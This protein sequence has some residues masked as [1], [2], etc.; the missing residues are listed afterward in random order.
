MSNDDDEVLCVKANQIMNNG[1]LSW[2]SIP[3]E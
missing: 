2:C 3:Y 1:V